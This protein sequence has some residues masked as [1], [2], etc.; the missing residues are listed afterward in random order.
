MSFTMWEQQ[1]VFKS[2]WF[3]YLDGKGNNSLISHRRARELERGYQSYQAY[4][5][6][7]R[8]G[9]PD[10]CAY[11]S[12]GFTRRNG[13]YVYENY[14]VDG[15]IDGHLAPIEKVLFIPEKI[16]NITI[17]SVA[18]EAFQG[19]LGLEQVVLNDNVTLID[20][21]AFEGCANLKEIVMPNQ[22]VH[23]KTDAFKNTALMDLSDA[24][25]LNNTL[26][27]VSPT[28]NGILTI[29]E[30]TTAIAD[31]AL[32][33]CISLTGVVFPE[34]LISIGS[35]AFKGCAGLNRIVLPESVQTIGPYAFSDCCALEEVKLPTT[36]KS[37]DSGAFSRC[38]ALTAVTLPEGITEINMF[39]EC[40]KLQPIRI[41][42]SV[43]EI[44]CGVFQDCDFF[45]DYLNS[46]AEELYV[47]NWLIHYKWEK[48]EELVVRSGT[49]GVACMNWINPQKLRSLT[50]PNTLKYINYGAFNYASITEV[51]LP[52][53]LL[54]ID[55]SAFRGSHLKGIRIPASVK[56]VETWAFMDCE[57]LDTIIVEGMT[58][59]IVW[60][61]ITGRKDK[62]SIRVYAPKGSKMHQYCT[63]YGE[64]YNLKFTPIKNHSI[65]SK[66]LKR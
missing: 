27:K 60:P 41:P 16:G 59:D 30:S 63:R 40:P 51:Q 39:G 58:T 44:S 34:G 29:K 56:T 19:E 38:T 12:R 7:N 21:R 2:G 33:G 23:I 46:D 32:Q 48:I 9:L 26:T 25:Y 28:F 36:M 24:F 50:L 10:E 18:R 22:H 11:P 1:I 45:K 20:D 61:A 53:G 66:L 14:C 15:M 42:S 13:E 17:N 43:R 35:Y 49:V 64:K 65:L 8:G 47:D 31:N 62:K 3:I 5:D 4:M 37:I 55:T 6:V 52:E 54:A 57:Q